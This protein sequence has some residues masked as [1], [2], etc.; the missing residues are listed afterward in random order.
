MTDGGRKASFAGSPDSNTN[1]KPRLAVIICAAGSSARMGGVKKEYRFLP[2]NKNESE[3]SSRV[4]TVLSSAVR[5]FVE[6]GLF[7]LV[8]VASPP[9]GESDA[10]AALAAGI[11]SPEAQAQ[12]VFIPGG[13]SRKTSVHNALRSL[14]PFSPDYVL[15][16][17]GARPWV[18]AALI[19][20]VTDAV[21]SCGAVIPVMPLVETPKEIDA[22]GLIVRHLR[23]ANVVSA[24]TPQAFAFA[25]ISAAHDCAE[26]D[27]IEYTDD[28][29]VWN[30]FTGPVHTVPG[31]AANRK[32]TFPEDLE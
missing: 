21:L 3:A 1:E 15:I 31:S 11:L 17:D 7:S 23:R 14:V 2:G 10:R 5:A 12:V 8:V 24:Q 13:P 16:H 30:A 20:R 27:G 28:A 9:G 6:T 26:D 18:D 4:E 32:I 25:G 22:Q 19:R 29:E